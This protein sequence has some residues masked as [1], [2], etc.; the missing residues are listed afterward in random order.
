MAGKRNLFLASRH[1]SQNLHHDFL[2]KKKSF[3]DMCCFQNKAFKEFSHPPK[4]CVAYLWLL[5]TL[6]QNLVYGSATAFF[7]TSIDNATILTAAKGVCEI[8]FRIGSSPHCPRGHCDPYLWH[9]SIWPLSGGSHSQLQDPGSTTCSRISLSTWV[10]ISPPQFPI[11]EMG[12][13]I[14]T[15]I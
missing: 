8:F 12:M 3:R 15:A 6:T 13:K 14:I 9:T 5:E 2:I 4:G 7:F 10:S 1:L 11:S